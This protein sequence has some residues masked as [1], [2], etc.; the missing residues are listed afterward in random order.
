MP[1][2]GTETCTRYVSSSTPHVDVDDVC[3]FQANGGGPVQ[4]L[5]DTLT[6]LFTVGAPSKAAFRLPSYCSTT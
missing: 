5:T 6:T 2:K 3:T 1:G 4:A